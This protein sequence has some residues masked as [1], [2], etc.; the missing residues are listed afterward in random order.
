[1]AIGIVCTSTKKLPIPLQVN[2]GGTGLTS[3]STNRLLAGSGLSS[4]INTVD[5]EDATSATSFSSIS[6]NIITERKVYYGLPYI[7]NS[8]TYTS[9][10]TYYAPTS[11][12]TSRYILRGNGTTSAPI[13]VNQTSIPIGFG[14]L[15]YNTA[16][17]DDGTNIKR[18]GFIVGISFT[19]ALKQGWHLN[20]GSVSI[21]GT[22]RSGARPYETSYCMVHSLGGTITG[23]IIV[24]SSGNVNIQLTS[25]V[26]ASGDNID[27]VG[28]TYYRAL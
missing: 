11:A 23:E 9:S 28:E 13:W 7:N 27:F 15:D 16:W 26:S 8:H 25:Y 2:Q 10:S 19:V 17:Q 3:I 20:A 14:Y 22:I 6:S 1:M 21:I 12:G 4:T 5:V 24:Y 18:W